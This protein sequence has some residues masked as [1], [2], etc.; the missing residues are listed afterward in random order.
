MD[1][2][3]GQL[4]GAVAL[5]VA[6]VAARIAGRPRAGSRPSRKRRGALLTGGI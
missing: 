1:L 5:W 4:A 6:D 3:A 2:K